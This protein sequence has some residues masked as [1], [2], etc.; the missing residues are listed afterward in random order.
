M[1]VLIGPNGTGKSSLF[2]AFRMWHR[3]H[4]VGAGTDATYHQKTG[5]PAIDWGQLV[6]LEFHEQVPAD[7]N[8]QK[9]IFYIRSAYRNQPDFTNAELRR[10][11]SPLDAPRV[12]KMIDNDASVSDNYQRLV[13]ATVAGVYDGDHDTQSVAQLRESFIGEVRSALQAVLDTVQLRGPGDPLQAGSFFFEKGVSRDFHYKNLS[14]GEKA[15]FDLLLDFVVKRRAFDN[16]VFCIDEPEAHMHTRL[17]ARLLETL[18]S[19]IPDN[20]QLWIPTHSV[21]MMR[22]AWDLHKQHPGEVS[23]IDFADRDFD[24]TLTIAPSA[25]DRQFWA[26]ALHVAV[27]D[28][29]TLVAPSRVV[30]CEGK[31]STGSVQHRAAFDA[32]C[33][34][35]IFG[36]EFPDTEFISAGNAADV[37]SDRLALKVAIETLVSGV[38]LI[39]LVDRDDRTPQ[40]IQELQANGVRVLSRRTIESYLLDDEPVRTLCASVGQQ[41]REAEVLAARDQALAD[42]VQRGNPTDDLKSAAGTFYNAAR[43]ILGLTQAGGN[44]DAFLRDT[45]APLV[46][47]GMAPYADL[48]A[49][50]FVSNRED[51]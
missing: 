36:A 26:S 27:D 7:S 18:F 16:T 34:R 20:C 9:K 51:R 4:G 3:F 42:S 48:R 21:G 47:P 24:T 2:D 28:L 38:T 50:I 23:F 35:Q 5:L 22:K 32:H 10:S 8:E 46:K 1:V 49:A 31:P 13:S 44:Q 33:Y 41:Q 37:A 12:E 15:V 45:M 39:R 14:A 19:L 25:V 43:S 30:L 17:Q 6:E 40:E 29:A 11:G